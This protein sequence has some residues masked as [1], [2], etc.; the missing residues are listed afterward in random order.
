MSEPELPAAAEAEPEEADLRR[1]TV[2]MAAGTAL[3]RVSGV[4]RVLALAYALG[5][6]HLADGYNLANTIPNML[7]DVVLGGVLAATF[8][9][10]FV[11][12]LSTRRERE[13]WRSISA[14][15][16]LSLIVLVVATVVIWVATPL[17]IDAFTFLGHTHATAASQNLG[18]EKAAATTL[19]RWFVPQVALYGVISLVTALLNT[20]RRFAAP[21]WVPI[22]NNLVVVV[23]LLWFKSVA[24]S[25]PSLAGVELHSGQLVLLGLGT[26]VGVAVQALLLLP[27]LR[28][29]GL[30]ELR[31]RW[32]PGD[33]AV[34]TIVRLGAW[35]FGFVI[36]NQVAL[37]VVLA[38]AV[39]APG[40]DP[41]SSYTYAY[42]FLQMP[43]AVVAVS[44][45][46]AVTPALAARWAM[47][48]TE[49]FRARMSGGL[50][51][52]LA[53][54]LPAAVGM[55]LLARPAV[56][57]LLGH[58]STTPAQTEPTGAALAMFS[59]G[60]PGFCVY[61]YV[62]RVLQTM[63]R[64]EVAFWLYLV[65]NGLNV[66]L[67]LL[68]VHPMGV[69]GLALSLSIAYSAAAVCGLVVLRR[70]L[71]HLAAPGA[72]RP[73]RRVALA[74]VA[75]G[76]VVLVVSNL[77]SADQGLGL[78]ARVA[79]AVVVGVLV[80]GG[81]AALLANRAATRA[82]S[83]DPGPV[84]PI[85]SSRGAPVAR[86]VQPKHVRALPRDPVRAI[87]RDV[88]DAW[89]ED[90]AD[91]GARRLLA[92]HLEASTAWEPATTPH[93]AVLPLRPSEPPGD[94]A[95]AA[96]P[97]A[98]EEDEHVD[99]GDRRLIAR[100]RD[101]EPP[102][103]PPPPAG[104]RSTPP[105]LRPVPPPGRPPAPPGDPDRPRRLW[106]PTPPRPSGGPNH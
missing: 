58:G 32:D 35:T 14:V 34:R 103:P 18:Q 29:L 79:A 19:L 51:A 53:V 22:A 59:I 28:G 7:Y 52:V 38:L 17:I 84:R 39:G 101:T 23:V 65:E 98:E 70:W 75:M 80:Y 44:V 85:A 10:V 47:A 41:V 60:L 76:L 48:D 21:T 87:A 3:S 30:G 5:P 93:V 33:D 49:S 55:L 31:P 20:R 74:T 13:A 1:A 8:I 57:L 106:P 96:D 43:Y 95:P 88:D 16:T 27:S 77:S 73:L 89:A 9:P 54:I 92:R 61:L 37:F 90:D 71:G 15:L 26:T 100:H 36:A 104:R 82:L 56:A 11:D 94:R 97:E 45:M 2:G 42:T 68:L 99:V 83:A 69:R 102:A 81:L 50:R 63:Q 40:A 66:V 62:V 4:A 78:L 25:K 24:G 86:H 72:W 105:A 64:T 91:E 46:S 67:A 12:R 6:T